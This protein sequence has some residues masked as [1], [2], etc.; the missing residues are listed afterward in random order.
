MA[1]TYFLK[2]T[3]YFR[4]ELIAS[5]TYQFEIV[6]TDLV[7]KQPIPIDDWAIYPNP[8]RDFLNI[9][10]PTN[11]T[12]EQIQLVTLTGQ[13]IPLTEQAIFKTDLLISLNLRLLNLSS[14]I[15]FLK[16]QNQEGMWRVFRVIKQ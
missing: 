5:T 4:K 14:G 16:M 12:Y 8:V 9:K 10:V 15:Y 11:T 2:G 13:I 3:A 1:G 6:P 7:T